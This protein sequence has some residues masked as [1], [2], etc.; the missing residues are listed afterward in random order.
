MHAR[1][2]MPRI[3]TLSPLSLALSLGAC[4]T[5]PSSPAALTEEARAGIA[6][7]CATL[8]A[9]YSH[10]LDAGEADALAALFS[11]DGVWQIVSNR[12]QGREAISRYWHGRYAQRKPGEGSRHV[13]TN[14]LIQ[15]VDHDHATGSAY[16]AVYGFDAEASKNASLAPVAFA[17]SQDEYV[18]TAE[19]WRIQLR[20]ILPVA[21]VAH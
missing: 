8:S 14:E 2:A 11:S 10:D 20:H 7:Q 21:N 1:P 3:A 13:I 16:F 18:R 12:M 9:A 4:A 19:G 15:I 17:I 5:H 6:Y